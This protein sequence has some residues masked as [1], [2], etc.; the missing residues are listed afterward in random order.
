VL[1]SNTKVCQ[2][3]CGITGSFTWL[4]DFADSIRYEDPDLAKR[5]D[6]A[7]RKVA[8]RLINTA[9]V[10][11][12]N[13]AW[14]NHNEKFGLNTINMAIDHG[15]TGAVYALAKMG[16]RLQDERIIGAARKAA[17]FVVS[18]TVADGSGIKMPHIVALDPDA[19]HLVGSVRSQ[20]R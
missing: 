15:Q 16:L 20:P 3:K 13:Y 9:Y 18:Q 6:E 7:I 17:D 2:C 12:G 5:C 1:T 4:G 10:V 14:E 19:K 11:D 8:Y